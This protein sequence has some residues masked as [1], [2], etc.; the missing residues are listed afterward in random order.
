MKILITGATGFVGHELTKRLLTEGHEINVLT[1]DISKA[2]KIFPDDRVKAFLWTNNL[3]LPPLES[4]EGINGVINLMGENIGAKRWSADQKI[5]LKQSRVDSTLNLVKL[6]DDNLKSPLDFFISASAVG[7]YPVNKPSTL[8][9]ETPA[10]HSFLADLCA[11][12]EEASSKLTKSKRRVLIRTAVVLEK[13]DGALKKMLPPFIIGLGG[14]IGDGNQMMSWIHRDDLVN[15][16]LAAV[17]N[18]NYNGVINA[19]APNPVNNFDFTKA[20]GHALHRPTII[21]VPT[22]PLKLAFGEMSTVI[23]D[24]QAVIS[25]R[26]PELGFQFKYPTINQAL[27]A[28]FKRK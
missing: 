15:L 9:E 5:K 3:E 16:Y 24:S 25:K 8:N 28:I 2:K 26:L 4:I 1:R 14:P 7:I 12:W 18:E 17:A 11:Q 13:D 6:L 10:A 20:L 27:D 21:P 22:I 19:T 23:L